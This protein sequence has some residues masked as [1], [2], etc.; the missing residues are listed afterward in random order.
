MSTA[1]SAIA[2]PRDPYKR[3]KTTRSNYELY[4]WI[5]MRASGVILIAL[6]FGQVDDVHAG[7]V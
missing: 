6:I 1:A 7:D 5:F 3:R 2:S 4:G